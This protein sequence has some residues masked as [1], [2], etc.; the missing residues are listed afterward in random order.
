MR[1]DGKR[2]CGR[3]K[4][5]HDPLEQGRQLT[6]DFYEGPVLTLSDITKAVQ[7]LKGASI[8]PY[9]GYGTYILVH[10]ETKKF[11]DKVWGDDTMG[12]ENNAKAVSDESPIVGY[13]L[14]NVP[15]GADFL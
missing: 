14:D 8:K 10:P 13:L 9:D 4:T 11:L 15:T 6:I 12:N 5:G 7:S 3:Y 2:R 1:K